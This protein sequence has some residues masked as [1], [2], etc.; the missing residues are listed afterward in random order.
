MSWRRYFVC[1]DDRVG[2]RI[3]IAQMIEFQDRMLYRL[4]IVGLARPKFGIVIWTA[5]AVVAIAAIAA[6]V[7]FRS[8][9]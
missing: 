1:D 5:T 4:P 3:H 2:Y 8:V 6:I 7:W 9:Q